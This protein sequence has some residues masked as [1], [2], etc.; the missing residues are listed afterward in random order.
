MQQISSRFKQALEARRAG[1]HEWARLERVVVG[2]VSAT[3]QTDLEPGPRWPGDPVETRHL[4]TAQ[5][6]QTL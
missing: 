6:A 4:L 2:Q 3:Q 1:R 5:L